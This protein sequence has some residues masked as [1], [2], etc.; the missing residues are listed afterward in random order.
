[1]IARVSCLLVLA[2]GFADPW[3]PAEAAGATAYRA[4]KADVLALLR[5]RVDDQH[6]AVGMVVGLID[7]SGPRIVAYGVMAKDDPRPVDGD[8]VFEVQSITKTFTT[9]LLADMVERGEVALDD[10][11]ARYLPPGVK[12]P[13]RNGRQITLLDLATHSSGLPDVFTNLRPRR[14][15]QPGYE[16]YTTGD[17]YAFLSGYALPRE[18]GSAWE[19]SSA[20]MALLGHAL[21]RRAGV[22]YAELV[23]RRILVPLGM[24]S[25][26]IVPTEAMRRRM[27][28]GHDFYLRR[29]QPEPW[30]ALTEPAWGLRSTAKDMLA[31]L[32]AELGYRDTPLKAAMAMQIAVRRRLPAWGEQG[33][34]WGV[35]DIPGGKAV[36]HDGGG[37]GFGAYAGFNT[38]TRTGVIVLTN[39]ERTTGA[40]IGRHL[41]LGTPPVPFPAP[42]L[43]TAHAQTVVDPALLD[44]YAGTYLITERGQRVTISAKGGQLFG[45]TAGSADIPL[46]PEGPTDFFAKGLDLLASFQ[47]Q[48]GRVQ[49]LWF[50]LNG[51]VLDAER[52]GPAVEGPATGALR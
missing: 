29:M 31:Y 1:M 3:R 13:E 24:T 39:R 33:L 15:G 45:Q 35:V 20:G 44:R 52:T 17:L 38:A 19:Y 36:I 6:M 30:P 2:G 22:D 48:D 4:S 11:V 47:V 32:G 18:P 14:D 40:D 16:P 49:G 34:G 7:A 25:S 21:A 23:R 46:Y 50:Q 43:P 37:H 12:V 42:R 8:T 28:G 5:K 9:L 27:A 51:E 26:A 41:I 10:P